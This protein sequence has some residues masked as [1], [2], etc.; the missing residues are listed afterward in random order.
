MSLYDAQNGFAPPPFALTRSRAERFGAPRAACIWIARRKS[1]RD[2]QGDREIGSRA[3]RD[4]WV[5]RC[6][7]EA[8]DLELS[9]KEIFL[10]LVLQNKKCVHARRPPD[11]PVKSSG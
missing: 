7:P 5:S 4:F 3:S 10:V 11:L 1:L 2:S 9:S 6:R 8:C